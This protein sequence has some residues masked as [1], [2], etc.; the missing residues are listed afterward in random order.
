M[1]IIRKS[2]IGGGEPEHGIILRARAHY[3]SIHLA[4]VRMKIINVHVDPS[5]ATNAKIQLFR[6]IAEISGRDNHEGAFILGDFNFQAPGEHR[7]KTHDAHLTRA[8]SGLAQH[9]RYDCS[10]CS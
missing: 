5:L 7:L 4:G 2:K 9:F 1:L 8:D 3:L 10:Q 6:D